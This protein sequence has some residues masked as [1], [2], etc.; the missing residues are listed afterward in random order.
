MNFYNAEEFRKLED[1]RMKIYLDKIFTVLDDTILPDLNE[2]AIEKKLDN[3]LINRELSLQILA[4]CFFQFEEQDVPEQMI[5]I[6]FHSYF[7]Y[8]KTPFNNLKEYLFLD[9]NKNRINGEKEHSILN[10]IFQFYTLFY[11][12]FDKTNEPTVINNVLA[13][14][15]NNLEKVKTYN[16]ETELEETD[17]K[18]EG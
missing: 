2:K 9:E 6:S 10:L 18:K 4:T 11:K 5:A 17:I 7:S 1:T 16:E 15:D 8:E 3:D 14:F 13:H 12:E